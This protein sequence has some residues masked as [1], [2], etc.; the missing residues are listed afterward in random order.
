M[1]KMTD[2]KNRPK[3]VPPPPV[4]EPDPP[5]TAFTWKAPEYP[6]YEKSSDWYWVLGIIALALIVVAFL[7][8][9]FLFVLLVLLGAFAVVLYAVRIPRIITVTISGRGIQIDD[10]LFPYE[11][12][13]SFWI[14]YRPGDHHELS[15]KSDR[16]LM[17]YI[18]IP[19]PDTD[20]NEI[21]EL[22]VKYLK[23]A[24]QE[25]S[26]VETLARLIGF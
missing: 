2:V 10:R 13:Q 20:P 17:P 8:K 12:L 26:M 1:P 21:R 9:N 5:K 25:E 6:Y 22:L 15:L 14:F 18:K 7:M 3:Q 11:T 4:P 24:K 23:E 19:L 16:T